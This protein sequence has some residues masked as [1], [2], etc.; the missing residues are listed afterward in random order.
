MESCVLLDF[1]RDLYGFPIL[2]FSY[3]FILTL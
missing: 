3:E 1:G 2:G